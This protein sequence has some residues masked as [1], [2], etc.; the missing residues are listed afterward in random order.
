[1]TQ[2]LDFPFSCLDHWQ[3]SLPHQPFLASRV[4]AVHR[5]MHP[6]LSVY[7]QALLTLRPSLGSMLTILAPGGSW[8]SLH[9]SP[10]CL[11]SLSLKEASLL[12]STSDAEKASVHSSLPAIFDTSPLGVSSNPCVIPSH[13]T[14]NPL[15]SKHCVCVC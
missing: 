15:E 4:V 13:P 9:K 10:I 14:Q 5:P 8:P 2:G 7:L 1:M 6:S 12:N 11:S 3:P